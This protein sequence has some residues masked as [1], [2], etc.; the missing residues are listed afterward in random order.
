MLNGPLN[1]HDTQIEDCDRLYELMEKY[2]DRPMDLA[3]ATLVL[4]AEELGEHRI[5]TTDSDFLFYRIDGKKCF[6]VLKP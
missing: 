5:L 4:V 6:E 1:I 2:S 3:D